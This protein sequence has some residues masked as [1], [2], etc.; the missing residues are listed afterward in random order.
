MMMDLNIYSKKLQEI[1][2][3]DKAEKPFVLS[4]AV[5]ENGNPVYSHT[6][7]C[8]ECTCDLIDSYGVRANFC[9][10]CGKRINW[11]GYDET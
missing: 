1:I 5:I 7:L 3:R 6:P 11:E 9:P 4:G 8:P 10:Q 2:Q